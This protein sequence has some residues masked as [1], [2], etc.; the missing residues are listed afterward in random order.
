[1]WEVRADSIVAK[2]RALCK[3]WNRY[4][5]NMGTVEDVAIGLRLRNAR[6]QKNLSQS[7]IGEILGITYQ[8]IQRYESGESKITA[9]S[10]ARIAAFLDVPVAYFYCGDGG[11]QAYPEP[12]VLMHELRLIEAWRKLPGD[13]KNSIRLLIVELVY[14]STA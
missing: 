5:E 7:K 10:L 11:E 3:K 9:T 1:M 8:Q 2:K 4:G 12:L 13:I 6:L 14:D